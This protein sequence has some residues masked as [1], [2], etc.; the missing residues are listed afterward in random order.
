MRAPLPSALE[1]LALEPLAT[2]A[3]LEGLFRTRMKKKSAG[4]VKAGHEYLSN[5]L[6]QLNRAKLCFQLSCAV[7]CG[8]VS[9]AEEA[10]LL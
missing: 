6:C 7:N 2:D 3:L 1:P 9:C 8:A 4:F 10:Q 5:Y